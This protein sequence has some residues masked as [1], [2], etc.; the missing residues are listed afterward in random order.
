GVPIACDPSNPAYERRL[1]AAVR[2]M[3]SPRGYG[4]DGFKIDFT[5]RI[6]AGPG[7]TLHG[8]TWG[9]ELMHDYLR[10]LHSEA[11]RAKRDSLVMTHT[12]HP[13][14]TDVVDMIRLNDANHGRDTK[15]D[16]NPSMTHRARLAAIACP[17]AIIDTDN[18]PM[19][20]KASW[21]AYMHLQPELGVP[22]LYFATHID[23]TG[24][25]L[26]AEDYRL[27]REVWAR[28][29]DGS[30]STISTELKVRRAERDEMPGLSIQSPWLPAEG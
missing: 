10:I 6:P 4:A 28:C 12:P 5:A 7:L 1:R 18:W 26:D 2:Q 14:L 3:I 8:D 15:R 22:S 19:P 29:R 21:R 11:R 13:Y 9:L 25:A 27:I 24:E 30:N 17:T 16:I 20:N 23:A